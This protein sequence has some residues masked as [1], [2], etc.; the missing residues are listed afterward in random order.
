MPDF[1]YVETEDRSGEVVR[2]EFHSR[3]TDKLLT[4]KR[5]FIELGGT[6]AQRLERVQK[7]LKLIEIL[8]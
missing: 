3:I 4:S 7:E 1:E 5:P 2:L 8:K 6:L